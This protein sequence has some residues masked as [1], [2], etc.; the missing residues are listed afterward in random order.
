[1]PYTSVSRAFHLVP[2]GLIAIAMLATPMKMK[3]TFL[4]PMRR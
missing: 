2:F 3:M 4:N 1:M